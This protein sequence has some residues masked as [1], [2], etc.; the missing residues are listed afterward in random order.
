[1]EKVNLIKV[2]IASPGDTK[3]YR[4]NVKEII[5]QWNISHV[6]L[7]L[8]FSTVLIPILWEDSSSPVYT[9]NESGQQVLN[10]QLLLNCDMLIAIFNKELGTEIDG[11]LSGTDEEISVFYGTKKRSTAVFFVNN[12]KD[13][14]D[15]SEVEEFIRL[16]KYKK[17]T[18]KGLYAEYNEK[19]INRY[20]TTEVNRILAIN[21]GTLQSQNIP[22]SFDDVKGLQLRLKR[23]D[24]KINKDIK[25]HAIY[26][27]NK[28]VVLHGSMIDP[29]DS[30]NISNSLRELR[31]SSNI[32]SNGILR[33]D[34]VFNSPSNAASFVIGN[35]ANGNTSWKLMDG[36]TLKEYKEEVNQK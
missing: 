17:E 12:I 35:S 32:D 21:Q 19:E 33:E 3:E 28:Y 14:L 26:N 2:F 4:E 31:H 10:K 8:D 23:H 7:N 24:V 25:A 1:M 36:R 16:R 9:Y 11:Y 29:V 20:I 27:D 5:Y 13:K 6:G 30:S 22:N 15:Q 18:G 34:V